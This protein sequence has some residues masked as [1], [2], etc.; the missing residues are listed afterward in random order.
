MLR[1]DVLRGTSGSL[2]EIAVLL[3]VFEPAA[4]QGGDFLPFRGG[5]VFRDGATP[6]EADIAFGTGLRSFEEIIHF[7]EGARERKGLFDDQRFSDIVDRQG[8]QR[9][10]DLAPIGV[11]V[12]TRKIERAADFW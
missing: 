3:E 12:N 5:G 4:D 11:E 1:H 10:V 8:G 6:I 2:H 7:L 9:L